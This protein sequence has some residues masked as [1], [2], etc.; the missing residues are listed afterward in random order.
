M[1]DSHAFRETQSVDLHEVLKSPQGTIGRL[2]TEVFR[3]SFTAKQKDFLEHG[4]FSYFECFLSKGLP[5]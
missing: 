2:Q 5:M 3:E 4:F 1:A